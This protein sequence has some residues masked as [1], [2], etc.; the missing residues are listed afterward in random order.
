MYA[1]RIGS[2][3]PV[4]SVTS[5]TAAPFSQIHSGTPG[6]WSVAL[7]SASS[8]PSGRISQPMSVNGGRGAKRSGGQAGIAAV[9]WPIA[10][11]FSM[12]GS[13]TRMTE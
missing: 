9:S 10:S 4:S 8:M 3:M 6:R 11:V 7:R 5:S 2:W 13:A 1:V 12:S